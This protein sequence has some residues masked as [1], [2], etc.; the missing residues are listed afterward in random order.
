MDLVSRAAYA[1]ATNCAR[2]PRAHARPWDQAQARPEYHAQRGNCGHSGYGCRGFAAA[3]PGLCRL[4][5]SV[6]PARLRGASP[7]SNA[8]SV[9][10]AGS[11]T[12]SRY[13]FADGFPGEIGILLVSPEFP[14]SFSPVMPAL[15][16]SERRSPPAATITWSSLSI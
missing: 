13:R 15:N 4:T 14:S 8:L 9:R 5:L 16:A 2:S 10:L 6:A 12:A 7:G 11:E 3:D 1:S